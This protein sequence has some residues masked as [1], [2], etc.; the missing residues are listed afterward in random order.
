VPADND[1]RCRPLAQAGAALDPVV[2]HDCFVAIAIV[3]ATR[4]S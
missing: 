3:S 1:A 2:V 4:R